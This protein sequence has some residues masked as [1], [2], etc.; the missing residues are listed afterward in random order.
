VWKF[1][2][3]VTISKTAAANSVDLLTYFVRDVSTDGTMKAI[4]V[5]GIKNFTS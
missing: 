5:A 2:S 1:P 4:D 3:G